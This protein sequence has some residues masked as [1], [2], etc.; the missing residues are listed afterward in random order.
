[1]KRAVDWDALPDNE[2]LAYDPPR[3]IEGCQCPCHDN[4]WGAARCCLHRPIFKAEAR[5]R[6]FVER[7]Q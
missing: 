6:D 5:G 7:A 2:P 4:G 1:M 3:T